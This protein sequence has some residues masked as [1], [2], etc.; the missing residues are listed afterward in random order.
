LPVSL[1]DSADNTTDE[2]AEGVVDGAW[3]ALAQVANVVVDLGVD[4]TLGEEIV[5]LNETIH[6]RDRP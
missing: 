3:A 6:R 4:V 1:G 2:C 5:T